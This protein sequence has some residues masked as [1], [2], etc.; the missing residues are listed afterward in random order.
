MTVKDPVAVLDMKS[1]AGRPIRRSDAVGAEI[2]VTVHASRTTQGLGKNLPAV[3]E[4]TRTVIVLQQGAVVR[5]TAS[6]MP[7]ETVVLTNRMTGADVLCRVGNVKTQPGIQHYV[8]LE[9]I[10]RAPGFWGDTLHAQGAPA[11]AEMT[12]VAAAPIEQV[13]PIAPPPAPVLVPPAVPELPAATPSVQSAPVAPRPVPVLVPPVVATPAPVAG[14]HPAAAQTL[15]PSLLAEPVTVPWKA[16]QANPVRP[17]RPSYSSRISADSG[18]A[19][20][21]MESAPG[22]SFGAQRGL[23]VAAAA[24]L[25]VAGGALGGYWF[26][27]RQSAAVPNPPSPQQAI[28]APQFQVTPDPTQAA[29]PVIAPAATATLNSTSL[30][31]PQTDIFVESRPTVASSVSRVRT[32]P[33]AATRAPVPVPAVRRNSVPIATLKAPKVKTNLA[34]ASSSDPPP[35]MV[36]AANSLGDTG[37]GNALLLGAGSGPAPP[38]AVGGQLQPPRL[39][40]ST[41]PTYPSHARAQRLQGVVVLDVLV[42]E[43]GKVVETKVVSGNA[44]LLPAAQDSLRTWKYQPAQLNGKPISVHT[45]VNVRFSLQ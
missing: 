43:T 2:P 14:P 23:L 7:G 33:A 15:Q 40:S 34:S 24:V 22:A 18:F 5:L 30:P 6:L 21:G 8:D 25:L 26:Y 3:H 12:A 9:F 4:E 13:A 27:G 10:Q 35:M 29:L 37:T 1:G 38:P 11:I 17:I 36:G 45:T 42:D 19:S 28:N 39:I 16:S 44:L 32:P 41:P 20:I 31:Q